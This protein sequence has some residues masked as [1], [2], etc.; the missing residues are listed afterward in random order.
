MSQ[1][2]IDWF[3]S[4]LDE[5]SMYNGI[6]IAMHSGFGNS[7]I[8]SRDFENKNN[9]ITITGGNPDSYEYFGDGNPC[10]IPDIIEAYIT[11]NNISCKYAS[12]K[13]GMDINVMTHFHTS[14]N[15]FIGYFGGHTHWDCIEQLNYHQGQL[16]FII[17]SA[18]HLYP[19]YY[20]DIYRE[21][22]GINAIT[23]NSYLIESTKRKITAIRLGTR[24]IVN[25][26]VRDRIELNY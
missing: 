5:S 16:Q 11:G 12:G 26:T 15:N 7:G 20:D 6:I 13:E 17:S 19:S 25:G 9:F 2:Q 4:V 18:N 14:H 1:K 3:I 24:K 22:Q 23:I 8:G 10:M 21:A